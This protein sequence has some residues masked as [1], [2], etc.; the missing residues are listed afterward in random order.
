SQTPGLSD[1]SYTPTPAARP[2]TSALKSGTGSRA[3]LT[4]SQARPLSQPKKEVVL[5]SPPAQPST[6]SASANPAPRLPE[7]STPAPQR[8]Q[9]LS[10][11]INLASD[12]TSDDHGR[13]SHTE[14]M[15]TGAGTR[16]LITVEEDAPGKPSAST[17]DPVDHT[18]KAP[19]RP[20]FLP[21]SDDE[22]ERLE[23]HPDSDAWLTRRS[24]DRHS[25]SPAPPSPGPARTPPPDL[26]GTTSEV[27]RPQASQ[28]PKGATTPPVATVPS[29]SS[30]VAGSTVSVVPTPS[31]PS[32]RPKDAP[33]RRHKRRRSSIGIQTV[34]EGELD[35]LA[36]M[37]V[38]ASMSAIDVSREWVRAGS[39]TRGQA[40]EQEEEEP[41]GTGFLEEFEG[42]QAEAE[43]GREHPMRAAS[44]GPFSDADEGVAEESSAERTPADEDPP[45]EPEQNGRA[46][47]DSSSPEPVPPPDQ[48]QDPRSSPAPISIDHYAGMTEDIQ[49]LETS[50]SHAKASASTIATPYSEEFTARVS[51]LRTS[52]SQPINPEAAPFPFKLRSEPDPKTISASQPNRARSRM[53]TPQPLPG[54]ALGAA[55]TLGRSMFG[56]TGVQVGS[57][58][59]DKNVLRAAPT[60]GRSMVWD[61]G[62]GNSSAGKP[63]SPEDPE[64]AESSKVAR[65]G[66]PQS[67]ERSQMGPTSTPSPPPPSTQKTDRLSSKAAKPSSKSQPPKVSG[68]T[69]QPSPVIRPSTPIQEREDNAGAGPSAAPGAITQG[70]DAEAG[71]NDQGEAGGS[72]TYESE[73]PDAVADLP[74][75]GTKSPSDSI[76]PKSVVTTDYDAEYGSVPDVP[77]VASQSES[78]EPTHIT[79]SSSPTNPGEWTLE[80]SHASTPQFQATLPRSTVPVLHIDSPPA[81]RDRPRVRRPSLAP[82]PTQPMSL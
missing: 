51:A 9:P 13:P 65:E 15:P 62:S 42:R 52:V 5:L 44:V 59:K 43:H 33:V 50:A 21:D 6:P 4:S 55:P 41:P 18:P 81:P 74:S 56:D 49:Q 34:P 30:R 47:H 1:K 31:T 71:S 27:G 61:S 82:S 38:D 75:Q 17:V 36:D 54:Q 53:Y 8:V 60:L 73:I 58:E 19:S 63:E 26:G 66:H 77:S 22:R 48:S 64:K 11:V 3:S 40:G 46:G 25:P 14:T 78:R 28:S 69:S 67:S 32:P 24:P 12:P 7:K 20:L 2:L 76:K 72:P 29:T 16:R 80:P 70:P 79:I 10:N 57:V 45:P 37:E 39:P 68:P 23:E 35:W